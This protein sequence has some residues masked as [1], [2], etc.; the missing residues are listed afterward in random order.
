M[1]AENLGAGEQEALATARLGDLKKI[2][3][4]IG[5]IIWNY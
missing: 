1:S 4:N 2:I 5:L 3:L